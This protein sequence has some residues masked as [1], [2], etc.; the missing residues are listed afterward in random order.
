MASP[1]WKTGDFVVVSLRST[2]SPSLPHGVGLH[3]G[4]GAGPRP[5]SASASLCSFR[6]LLCLLENS[7][8]KHPGQPWAAYP[9]QSLPETRTD[10]S[11]SGK[12]WVGEEAGSLSS[13]AWA[14]T[15][16]PT[17]GRGEFP[18]NSSLLHP[19]T[20]FFGWAPVA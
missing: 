12:L 1:I 6:G 5:L 9:R 11:V 17:E 4:V 3:S 7:A 20:V 8:G 19:V 16:P 2:T 18:L 14:A 13:G 15:T 10:C